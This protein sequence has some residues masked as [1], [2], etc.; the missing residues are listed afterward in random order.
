M[1]D[2]HLDV[3]LVERPFVPEQASR[4]FIARHPEWTPAQVAVQLA[5]TA[6]DWGTRGKDTDFGYGEVNLFEAVYGGPAPSQR[7]VVSG[8]SDP[9]G[10][11]QQPGVGSR[12]LDWVQRT[13]L[14]R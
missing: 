8:Y 1:V 2:P 12:L 9:N 6:N 7:R 14:G 13:F 10:G 4:E 11:Y 5:R 3:R